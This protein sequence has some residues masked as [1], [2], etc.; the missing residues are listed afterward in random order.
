MSDV[1]TER[2]FGNEV[3]LGLADITLSLCSFEKFNLPDPS[4]KR[5]SC[6]VGFSAS[7]A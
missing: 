6:L 3:L 2:L 5:F 1:S 4:K 7:D